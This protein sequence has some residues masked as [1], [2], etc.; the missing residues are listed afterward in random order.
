M[1]HTVN[2]CLELA[3]KGMQTILGHRGAE[4]DIP[5]AVDENGVVFLKKDDVFSGSCQL[6]TLVP[7]KGWLVLVMI[8]S[9]F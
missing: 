8:R 1:S 7:N 3:L 6:F 5:F 4:H 9:T 2:P